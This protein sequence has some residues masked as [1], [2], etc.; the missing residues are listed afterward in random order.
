MLPKKPFLTCKKNCGSRVI[1]RKIRKPPIPGRPLLKKNMPGAYLGDWGTTV[2]FLRKEQRWEKKK[3]TVLEHSC[4]SFFSLLSL[5]LYKGPA[6]PS[7]GAAR[8]CPACYCWQAQ[9]FLRLSV[10]SVGAIVMGMLSRD[11]DG[12]LSPSL[13]ICFCDTMW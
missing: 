3:A 5:L 2:L 1:Q 12:S 10:G 4:A 6:Q 8:Q 11:G 9:D 13:R 7:V